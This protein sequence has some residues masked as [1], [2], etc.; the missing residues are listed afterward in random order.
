MELHQ[1]TDFTI[2]KRFSESSVQQQRALCS[3]SPVHRQE[4]A[5]VIDTIIQSECISRT[6]RVSN[7]SLVVG[8]NFL[9]TVQIPVFHITRLH[10]HTR[11]GQTC[12]QF[13]V[14]S[15]VRFCIETV[16]HIPEECPD[17]ISCPPHIRFIRLNFVLEN[18]LIL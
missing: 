1:T 12:H 6:S 2:T 17:R 5:F 7:D 8:S 15:E 11:I 14:L 3:T 10:G 16:R 4:K 13:A 18:N 9:I